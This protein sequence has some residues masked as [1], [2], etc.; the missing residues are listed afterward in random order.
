MATYNVGIREVHVLT[1]QV[2]LPDEMEGLSWSTKLDVL[3]DLAQKRRE[4]GE[5]DMVEFSH[6]LNK[7]FWSIERVK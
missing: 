2:E 1:V 5:E 7:E 3:K 6:D 4:E